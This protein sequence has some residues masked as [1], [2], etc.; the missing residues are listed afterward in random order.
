MVMTKGANDHAK[1]D[2]PEGGKY[3]RRAEIRRRDRHLPRRY[4][5]WPSRSMIA[6][7][8]S[9]SWWRQLL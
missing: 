7:W 1:E 5:A 3:T 4:V 8:L 6:M 9:C 2:P